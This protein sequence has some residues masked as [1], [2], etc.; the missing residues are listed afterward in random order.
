MAWTDD[1]EADDV[2][3]GLDEQMRALLE[4]IGGQAWDLGQIEAVVAEM[5]SELTVREHEALLR[6]WSQYFMALERSFEARQRP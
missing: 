5:V 2:E 6:Y 3:W 1:Y 4:A